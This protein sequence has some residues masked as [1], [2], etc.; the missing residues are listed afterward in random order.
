MLNRRLLRSKAVQ[1]LYATRI[2]TDANHQLAKDEIADAYLPDLNS[3]L[4]QNLEKLEGLKRL[5]LIT[6]AEL[7]ENGE[8]GKDEEVPFEVIQ[9]ARR[10]FEFMKRQNQKDRIQILNRILKETEG[11]YDQFLSV[12][13]LLI[14]LAHQSTL[15]RER[16]VYIREGAFPTES[17]LDENSVI[18]N[19]KRNSAFELA[20]IRSGISWANDLSVVRKTYREALRTDADYIEYCKKNMHTPEE[21]QQMVQH[22]LRQIILKHE[23]P[24]DYFQQKDLYWEEHAD[25]IK[26]MA[27][28][29]LK[30]ASKGEIELLELTDDWEEDRFFVEELVGKAIE[31]DKVYEGYLYEQLKNWDLERIAL[32]DMI[33]MKVA[34]T[35]MIHFPSIPVKVTINEFIEIAKRYSTLKSGKFVNGNLDR[36]AEKLK[37]EGVIRKSGRG[38]IDNR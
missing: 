4:P 19:L 25:L 22:I 6:L 16:K 32:V 29:T 14:E 15:D 3:M 18:L 28:K 11:L 8:P 21:D 37:E 33:I 13:S 30:S 10:A 7:I 5:A 2:A 26:S 23:I 38:L 36:L 31:N 17:G 34:L 9:T 24:L 12:L 27:I 20:V 35:E 1:A